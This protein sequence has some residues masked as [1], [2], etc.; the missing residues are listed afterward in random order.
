MHGQDFHSLVA[1]ARG[2][3][4]E[5]VA[6]VLNRVTV[7]LGR[8][9][10]EDQA[11]LQSLK[12][13]LYV[14]GVLDYCTTAL[15]FNYVK[16]EGGYNTAVQMADILS[17]CCVG[18]GPVK[19]SE[20]F[21]CRFLPSV[22]RNL[23]YLA[24]RLMLRAMRDKGQSQKIHQFRKVMNSICWFLKAHLHLIPQVLD[25]KHYENIQLCD[26]DE[27]SVLLLDM[28]Q[29]LLNTDRAGIVSEPLLLIMDDIVYKMSSSSNPVIGSSAVRCL[30][31]LIKQHGW[32][33][34]V[35]QR[36]YKGLAELIIKDW[37]GRGFNSNL[38]TLTALLKSRVFQQD[39]SQDH[40][41]RVRAACIIQAAW[42]AHQTRRRLLKLPQ[43]IRTLQRTFRERKWQ[44]EEQTERRRVEEELRHNL[45]L[46]R[47]RANRLFCQKQL[48]LL[49]ILPADQ[50]ERYQGEVQLRAA[51]LIQRVWRGQRERRSIC[52][53]RHALQQ[54]KAALIIQRAVILFLKH[55]RTKRSALTGW[56]GIQGLT[57]ARRAE[58]KKQVDKHIALYRL[59]AVTEDSCRTFHQRTQGLLQQ[60]LMGRSQAWVEEQHRLPI[61]EEQHSTGPGLVQEPLCT[62]GHMCQTIAQ[63]P[64]SV[65]APALVENAG[66]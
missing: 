41:E 5:K 43:A 4:E 18:I 23:F 8:T 44:R 20:K 46:R 45:L 29:E 60:H 36:H 59:S 26:D 53:Q 61:P 14:H 38:N 57:D 3:C 12:Q 66:T 11:E 27:I 30:L 31:L 55:C 35:I 15:R 6:D 13:G 21:H 28:W 24:D 51:L 33:L 16:A 37:H 10:L 50:V 32:I 42:R 49:E 19:K 22:T 54:H 34:E 65:I 1:A 40:G 52:Q 25:C 64:A 7:V 2:T 63:C 39:R 47:Q 48:R 62:I 9:S 58:L 56:T 17:T